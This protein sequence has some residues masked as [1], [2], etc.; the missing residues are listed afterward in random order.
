MP[1]LKDGKVNILEICVR[2]AI[3]LYIQRAL[4]VAILSKE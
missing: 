3:I 1:L 2:V 4:L